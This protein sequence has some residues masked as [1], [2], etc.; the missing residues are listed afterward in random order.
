MVCFLL[1]F[2][3]VCERDFGKSL[4]IHH[5]RA[6]GKGVCES[7]SDHTLPVPWRG[8]GDDPVRVCDN[9]YSTKDC[10]TQTKGNESP[11]SITSRYISENITHAAG[12]VGG[13]LLYPSKLMADVTRPEYW[14]PDDKIKSCCVCEIEFGNTLYKHHCR[15]CGKGVCEDCSQHRLPVPDKGWDY[16]V[17][18]C[19][20]CVNTLTKQ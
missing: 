6:C 14:V 7:C 18:V 12:W 16:E 4:S 1:Q 5:C 15:G 2:C 17:R 8:W 10:I 13:A 20:G 19:D 9:C 3:F 11:K